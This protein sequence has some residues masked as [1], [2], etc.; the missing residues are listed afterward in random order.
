MPVVIETSGT[1][2]DAKTRARD[3][4]LSHNSMQSLPEQINFRVSLSYY[5]IRDEYEKDTRNGAG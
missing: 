4:V 2:R 1:G 3:A 5:P